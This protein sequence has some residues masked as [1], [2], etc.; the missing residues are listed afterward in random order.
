MEGELL[1]SSHEFPPGWMAHRCH[2]P[3]FRIVRPADSGVD[4]LFACLPRRAFS[5]GFLPRKRGIAH[6]VGGFSAINGR[7][8]NGVVGHSRKDARTHAD[9][10]VGDPR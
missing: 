10:V 8:E 1:S 7:F 9:S 3:R 4:R 2:L 6:L 5:P